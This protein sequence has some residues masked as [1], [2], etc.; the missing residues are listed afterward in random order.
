[1]IAPI[2]IT[3][4]GVSVLVAFLA[5]GRRISFAGAFFTSVFM[6]PLVGLIAI[7]KTDK[8]LKIKY[9]ITRYSCP[10]CNYEYTEEKECCNFCKEMGNTVKLEPKRIL[11]QK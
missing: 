3:Y 9:Y 4:I 5:I 10:V 1:M 7:L 6:S 8:N 2:I 11:I